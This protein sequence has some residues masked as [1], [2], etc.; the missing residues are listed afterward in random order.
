MGCPLGHCCHSVLMALGLVW[1]VQ[2]YMVGQKLI[3]PSCYIFF[4]LIYRNS[5]VRIA[6]HTFHFRVS[7]RLGGQIVP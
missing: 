7:S 1:G 5:I 4:H 3:T 6:W 2:H